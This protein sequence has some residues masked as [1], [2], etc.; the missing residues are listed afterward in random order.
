MAKVAGRSS[1]KHYIARV[2]VVDDDD[3]DDDDEFEGVFLQKMVS[4]VNA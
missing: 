4:K 3:D 2:D 1:G